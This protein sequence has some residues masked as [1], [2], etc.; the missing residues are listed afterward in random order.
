M[1]DSDLQQRTRALESQGLLRSLKLHPGKIDF[2]SNDYLGLAQNTELWASFQRAISDHRQPALG[3]TGSRLL[4]GNSELAEELESYF[5][6]FFQC[7]GA[8]LLNSGYMANMAML[9]TLAERNHV[10]LYDSEAHASIKDAARL[11]MAKCFAF[12]H[13]DLADLETKLQ[14]TARTHWVVVESLYSMSGDF[15]RLAEISELC[16][17][18]G[19]R[20]LVDEA[21]T[22][23]IAGDYGEGFCLQQKV[24]SQVF[25]RVH[26]FGKGPASMGAVVCGSNELKR[27]LISRARMFIYTTA[28]PEYTLL[29]LKLAFEYLQKNYAMLISAL[30]KNI[31]MFGGPKSS[32]SPIQPVL[33]SGVD[34]VKQKAANLQA[35][36]LL[37]MPIVSPTVPAGHE[38]LRI[39]LHSFNTEDE[40]NIL[41][42]GLS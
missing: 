26:T 2:T 29:H 33:V 38:R 19:A 40:I 12:R 42:Q 11:S 16:Q 28:L 5:A 3:S 7:Q 30:R 31:E 13:N 27:L 21:H 22:T 4:A 32:E 9:T 25:A 35:S 14:Q 37:V 34:A 36:G 10:I 6:D 41:K 8:L 20:L 1:S 15:A 17:R 24:A 18:H 23:G 39:C